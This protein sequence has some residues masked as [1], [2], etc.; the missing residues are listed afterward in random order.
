MEL[1][2]L[3]GSVML[4]GGDETEK[5]LDSIDKKGG[6]LGQ[7]LGKIG[8]G[9]AVV[10]TAMAGAGVAV[11]GM[12]K[13]ASATADNVDKMSQKI[14]ISR[15]AYQEWDF[16]LSQSGASVDGLQ[17]GV[18]TLSKAAFEASQGV[19][20]YADN[21][22]A[23]GISVTDANGKMKDQETLLTETI[24]ALS[25]MDDE[26]KRTAIASEL[27]GRSA[28]ELAPMLNAG[29]GAVEDMRAKAHEL[30]LVLEDEAID[31]GVNFTD[32]M[33]QLQRTLGALF[34]QALAPLLPTINDL[35][36]EF[37][38]ILPPLMEFIGPL[39]EKL[40]PVVQ[41]LIEALLPVFIR[42]LDALMPI[43]DPLIDLF[44]MLVDMVLLPLIDLLLPIVEALMPVFIE[45]L[46][47]LIPVLQPILELFGELLK[48]ILPPLIGIIMMLT[49]SALMPLIGS[50][51][52]LLL[53]ILPPLID[54]FMALMPAI[55]P[56]LEM[57]GEL[58]KMILPPLIDI[59]VFVAKIVSGIFTESFEN[60]LPVFEN[61]MKTIGHLMSFWL[62]VFS[63]NWAG[64][65]ESLR[66]YFLSIWDTIVSYFKAVVNQI[67]G[68][69]NVLIRGLNKISFNIPDWVPLIGGKEFGINIGEIPKLED[70]GEIDRSGRVLVGEAGPEVLDLPKG[71]RVSPLD[72]AGV[73]LVINNP[74]FFSQRD[75]DKMLEGA[76]RRIKTKVATT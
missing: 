47:A 65:W 58:L 9:A 34:T 66:E 50:L 10:G 56:L 73:T 44:L 5:Q 33:D 4:Q 25:A 61:I 42:L 69:I 54:I 11:M 63:G 32:T 31:S 64:A 23:L 62:N 45:L 16:I 30:G 14:G 35:A 76:V 21:F 57:L 12:A 28:T 15:Q 39:V 37:I 49:N 2:R 55:E 68:G 53:D 7:T 52:G 48:A 75:M 38:K 29:A 36:Q 19:S 71:A 43:L 41:R 18:K 26:T 60:I 67:I 1:F 17:M 27:L 72:K 46:T 70:G 13:K 6:G 74:K 59:L 22:D 8:K 24:Q 3:F 51:S 20:T 40:I